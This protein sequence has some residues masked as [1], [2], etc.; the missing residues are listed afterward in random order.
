MG[1]TL[2]VTVLVA[3]TCAAWPAIARADGPIVR[4]EEYGD[5]PDA[6]AALQ[7]A[8]DAE[9]RAIHVYVTDGARRLACEEYRLDL[10]PA[11][12]SAFEVGPCD[13][14][15]QATALRLV[16]RARLFSHADVVPRPRAIA[17]AATQ[18]RQ[19]VAVGRAT[20]AA[21]SELRCSLAV[22]PY[23]D[24]LEHGGRF[25]LVPGRF[26]L[27]LE[28]A[29]ATAEATSG[30][31]TVRGGAI[32]VAYTIVD[33]AR[34]MEVVYR[35]RVRLECE[36]EAP[37]ALPAAA[38]PP[39]LPHGNVRIEAAAENRTAIRGAYVNGVY[40]ELPCDLQLSGRNYVSLGGGRLERGSSAFDV[41]AEPL[42]V[43]ISRRALEARQRPFVIMGATIGLIMLPGLAGPLFLTS[44]LR[45][46][47]PVAIAAG[48]VCLGLAGVGL[49]FGPIGIALMAAAGPLESIQV[50]DR[51]ASTL[52]VE[53]VGVAPIPG[54]GAVNMA[55]RF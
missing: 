39:P 24:D 27:L 1:R 18:V 54:G 12:A 31:W 22:R 50:R 17:I 28:S 49:L 40:C 29:N 48:G 47:E 15:T 41:G 16:R 19:S 37:H 23:V 11:G 30:G 3:A 44:G 36:R 21:G 52:R 45:S 20:D 38:L 6:I 8:L 26:R 46:G 32:E 14:A 55:M 42:R 4:T 34:G 33:T 35:D 13:G 25:Y 9:G 53:H 43:T 51:R 2:G 7:R 10:D 5:W